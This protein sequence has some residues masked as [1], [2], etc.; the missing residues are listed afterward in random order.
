M[1]KYVFI[2]AR[3]NVSCPAGKYVC[4]YACVCLCVCDA[5]RRFN[6]YKIHTYICTYIYIYLENRDRERE[7]RI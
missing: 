3:M 7:S 5:A 4:Q 2:R 6:I 1:L